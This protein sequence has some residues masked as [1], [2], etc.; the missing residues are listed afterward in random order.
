[1]NNIRAQA[2]LSYDTNGNYDSVCIDTQVSKGVTAAGTAGGG[3]GVCNDGSSAWAASAPLKTAE[4]SNAYWCVDS[5][6]NSKGEASA[7]G[8]A[9]ACS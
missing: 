8:S 4:G 1:L 9:T 7:L 6:G 5:T 3:T 2:E